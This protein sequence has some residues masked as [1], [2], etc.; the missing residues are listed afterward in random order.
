[1]IHNN[2]IISICSEYTIILSTVRGH[3]DGNVSLL[4]VPLINLSGS[5]QFGADRG[6][7]KI[8]KHIVSLVF[9]LFT[10]ILTEHLSFYENIANNGFLKISGA[11]PAKDV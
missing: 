11:F 1:M 9:L 6:H 8:L 3:F 10:L 2:Y 4:A 5:D 7:D